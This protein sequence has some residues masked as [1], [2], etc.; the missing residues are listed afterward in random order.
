[1]ESV[2]VVFFSGKEGQLRWERVQV[3]G[4]ELP[5][6]GIGLVDMRRSSSILFYNANRDRPALNWSREK[7]RHA[8]CSAHR[9]K[10]KDRII[11][12]FDL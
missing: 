4:G 3:H 11:F 12:I 9:A 6:I 5:G 7:D 1:M 8:L 10:V 2:S